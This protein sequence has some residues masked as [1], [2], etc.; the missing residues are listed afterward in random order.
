[1]LVSR[2]RAREEIHAALEEG[3]MDGIFTIGYDLI[4]S[5][6]REHNPLLNWTKG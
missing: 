4:C 5:I 1:M 2:N 6:H 3:R